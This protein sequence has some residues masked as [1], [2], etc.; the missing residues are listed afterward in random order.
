[1]RGYLH[2][3]VFTS[4]SAAPG[5]HTRLPPEN[6]RT[7]TNVGTAIL[8]FINATPEEELPRS[9]PFS[10]SSWALQ[11]ERA[12]ERR[13]KGEARRMER[14]RGIPSAQLVWSCG[15]VGSELPGH[16]PHTKHIHT[17]TATIYVSSYCYICTCDHSTKY[18]SSFIILLL[19]MWPYPPC[20]YTKPQKKNCHKKKVARHTV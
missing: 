20:T 6:S 5:V 13:D 12:R 3:K 10:F 18:A 1:M 14:D 11:G 9:Q 8:H 19:H 16:T 15:C 4:A 17:H 7:P 2:A